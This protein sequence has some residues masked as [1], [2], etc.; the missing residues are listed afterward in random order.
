MKKMKLSRGQAMPEYI[1]AGFFM[2]VM[3][4]TPLPS[5]IVPDANGM[6]AA[7]YIVEA[8]KRNHEGYVWAMSMPA[9]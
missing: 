4:F 8:F 7:E 3:L 1:V 5:R 2:T 6:S 9:N